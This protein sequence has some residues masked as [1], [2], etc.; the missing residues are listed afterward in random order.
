MAPLPKNRVDICRLLPNQKTLKHAFSIGMSRISFKFFKG[1][2]LVGF[3]T[4][5]SVR[6]CVFY[7]CSSYVQL[8]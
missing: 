3:N 4:T 7:V 8:Q 1:L 6:I 5:H 2:N